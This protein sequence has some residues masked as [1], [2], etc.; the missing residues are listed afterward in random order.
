MYAYLGEATQKWITSC[1]YNA[2]SESCGMQQGSGLSP[3]LFTCDSHVNKTGDSL[4]PCCIPRY[5]DIAFSSHTRTSLPPISY[6]DYYMAVTE[7]DNCYVTMNAFTLMAS[8]RHDYR[9]PDAVL[10]HVI[11]R[12]IMS[13]A[14]HESHNK[15]YFVSLLLVTWQI[16]VNCLCM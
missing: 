11:C 15:Y 3:A 5:S 2:I 8:R 10:D 13:L 6:A 7:A 16:S 9:R 1:E 4:D 12:L 14:C